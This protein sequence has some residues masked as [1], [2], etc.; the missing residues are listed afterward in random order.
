MSTQATLRTTSS[1]SSIRTIFLREKSKSFG[2]RVSSAEWS[3]TYFRYRLQGCYLSSAVWRVAWPCGRNWANAGEYLLFVLYA[4]DSY[5]MKEQ[6]VKFL[7]VYYIC[8]VCRAKWGK[9]SHFFSP[10]HCRQ[11]MRGKLFLDI[12]TDQLVFYVLSCAST[13]PAKLL[14]ML[15]KWCNVKPCVFAQLA[16]W[17]G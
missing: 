17:V 6:T 3:Y 9:M 5:Q 4:I 16:P 12:C 8:H 11:I 1:H 2:G 10:R 7:P 14:E 15:L 13:F